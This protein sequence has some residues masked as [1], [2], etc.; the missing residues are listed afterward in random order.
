MKRDSGPRILSSLLL[1]FAITALLIGAKVVIEHTSWGHWLDVNAYQLL[2]GQ[3]A[4]FD[5]TNALPVVV[6]DISKIGE[7]KDHEVIDLQKLKQVVNAIADQ[8]PRAIGIDVVLIPE[9]DLSDQQQD[10]QRKLD[11]NYFNFLD[12]CLHSVKEERKIP[13]F[14]GVGERTIDKPEEWLGGAQYKDLA[15][16]IIIPKGETTRLPIWFESEAGSEKIFSMGASLARSSHRIHS[17][18]G[19][20][21]AIESVDDEFPG[22]QRHLE[23]NMEFADALINYSKLEAIQQNKLLTISEASVKEAGEMFRDRIV[24]LGDGTNAIAGDAFVVTGRNE[25][26]SGVYLHAAAVYTFARE[27]M[28][29]F[30][31]SVRFLLDLLLSGFIIFYVAAARY[32]HMGDRKIYDWHRLQKLLV[33]G[34]LAAVAMLAIVL[35]RYA[36]ILW[37]D[38]L[39]VIIALLIHPKIEAKLAGSK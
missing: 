19:L 26:F 34:V 27:P 38:F 2:Q 35:V 7:S 36:G 29:E 20:G 17:P 23:E 39:S 10:T 13:M 3:L 24:L 14:V 15:A 12:F 4:P 31:Y 18:Q 21:W 30:K 28:Y 37:L 1:G 33:W 6:V 22:T 16:T 9:P 25:P 11:E 32:R 8:K 5:T